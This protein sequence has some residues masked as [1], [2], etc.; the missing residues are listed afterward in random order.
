MRLLARRIKMMEVKGYTTTPILKVPE[1]LR[2]PQDLVFVTNDYELNH[3]LLV[4]R[5]LR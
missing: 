3:K 5:E 1:K 4:V 2:L